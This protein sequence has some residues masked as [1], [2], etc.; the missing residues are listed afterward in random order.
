MI[1][2]W[3]P[4][5]VDAY[6][7]SEVGTTCMITSEEWLKYPGSVGKAVERLRASTDLPIAVG[8]G[9]RTPEQAAAIARVA[10][11]SVVG[12]AFCQKVA[13]GLDE[14]GRA[15]PDCVANVLALAR[16]LGDGV[17]GARK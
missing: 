17:R 15:K 16:A 10:D 5:F 7:A 2:W 6:G 13:D 8:F 9:I 3:G 4:V 1:E 12:T 14:K 11:A